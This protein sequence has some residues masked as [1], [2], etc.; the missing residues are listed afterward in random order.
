MSHCRFIWWMNMVH[1]HYEH[2]V[3]L[4]N[5]KKKTHTIVTISVSLDNVYIFKKLMYIFYCLKHLYII[6]FRY[7][8]ALVEGFQAENFHV[9]SIF[10]IFLLE[11]FFHF[12]QVCI[13]ILFWVC[14]RIFGMWTFHLYLDLK[15]HLSLM[16]IVKLLELLY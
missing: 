3:A 5:L 8:K 6:T 10:L 2:I 9:F 4:M 14:K 13:K 7:I 1:F 11:F 16:R 12:W 15:E